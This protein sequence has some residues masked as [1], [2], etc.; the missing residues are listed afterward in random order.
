MDSS[1]VA[2]TAQKQVAEKIY[3][4][5]LGLGLDALLDDRD[6]RPGVK[7]KDADLIGVPFRIN[8]GKKLAEGLVELVD[9]RT[10]QSID[11]PA[12][13]APCRVRAEIY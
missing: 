3:R 7:F 8:A 13:E 11:V 4:E 6:E 1:A 5:C 9:R 10:K 12:A 2:D